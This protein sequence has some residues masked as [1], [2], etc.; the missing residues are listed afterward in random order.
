R[1]VVGQESPQM[2]GPHLANRDDSLALEEADAGA[3]VALVGGTGERREPPLDAAVVEE[4][5]E[6]SVHDRPFGRPMD[7]APKLVAILRLTG[8]LRKA[9]ANAGVF[10][11]AF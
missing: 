1:C 5:G 7:A 2:R 4:V 9:P 11:M 8:L 6:F 3:D 10:Y